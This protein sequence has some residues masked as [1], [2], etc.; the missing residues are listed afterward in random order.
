MIN[1][2]ISYQW[3]EEKQGR[4]Q[5]QGGPGTVVLDRTVK[6]DSLKIEY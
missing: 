5:E 2:F 1:Q 4:V 6:K 3:Y